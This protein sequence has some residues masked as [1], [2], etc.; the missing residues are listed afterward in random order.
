MW[1]ALLSGALTIG[2]IVLLSTPISIGTTSVPPLGKFLSPSK[3]FW[4]NAEGKRAHQR[5][6]TIKDTGLSAPVTVQLDDRLVP[7]IFA[8]NEV[9]AA[10]A[11]GYILAKF[12]LFQMDLAVRATA[13]TLS[14]IV[15]DRA[16]NYDKQQRN[17]GILWAA[18][19]AV[20]GWS[21]HPELMKVVQ[22]YCDGVNHYINSLPKRKYPL[23]FKLLNYKPELWTPLK[24]ALFIKKM[25]LDL[26][27]DERDLENTNLI[28]LLGKETFDE[29]FPEFNDKDIPIIPKS[30]QW[31][32][33]P[34]VLPD[35]GKPSR[36]IG[37]L[38]TNSGRTNEK[39]Q[40]G[41]NNW[42]IAKENTANG[43]PI[44]CSDPHLSLNLPSIWFENHLITPEF[45]VYGVSLP[46][47]PW[48]V[49][50]FNE[51][52]GW[53]LTN[54]GHDVL[55]W[56]TVD[57]ANQE[58][59]KYWIDGETIAATQRI[60][61]IKIKN[62]STVL[63]TVTYTVWGP[64]MK[65]GDHEGLAMK[66]IAHEVPQEAEVNV[67]SQ[68]NKAKSFD[69]Y[70][71]ALGS[72]SSP[73]QNFAFASI[74]NDI[75]LTIGGKLP[76]R[77]KEQGKFILD[78]SRTSDAWQAYI[79]YEHNPFV[80]NPEQ[81]YVAS[82]NQQTADT[83]YPY[84]YLATPYFEDYRGRMVNQYLGSDTAFTTEDMKSF[85]TSTL[86]LRAKDILPEFL[87]QVEKD[88][89]VGDEIRVVQILE[90][91]DYQYDGNSTAPILFEKLYNKFYDL[92]WDEFES[93]SETHLVAFPEDWRTIEL[94]LK[95][96]DYPFFDHKGTTQLETAHDII[97][98]SWKWLLDSIGKEND[99]L[100]MTWGTY[101]PTEISHLL[102]LDGFGHSVTPGS[103]GDA[104]NAISRT[105]GPSWRMI[106]EF[107]DRPTAQVIYPGGQSGN[108]G[109]PYYD[110]MI[111]DWVN[112]TYHAVKLVTE[113]EDISNILGT[114][115]FN[116]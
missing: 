90:E 76:L 106:V 112:G 113:Q 82:A 105:T 42:A 41:S 92:T 67:F 109:S 2:L 72:F 83:T 101:R 31:P 103:H 58:K 111:D 100:D 63:D 14:E 26:C 54:V 78:G 52:I 61:E 13:G 40:L 55:D 6:I 5:E 85:Q 39:E 45:N 99:L 23:E 88:N 47:V 43:N 25:A 28:Q 59:T 44:L 21:R 68:L 32:F 56:Y 107:T 50:G 65:N 16:V 108:P 36:L 110:N 15:G 102:S 48:V 4:R 84:Y 22:G 114:I 75:A 7:H 9:D 33:D 37:K 98:Q 29:L 49:I 8:G 17:Q 86:N 95:E 77:K 97:D 70:R 93:F 19:N 57:W 116:K 74:N 81:G 20:E 94:A 34:I 104:L 69:D 1:K 91:W 46:G 30:K 53:A 96:P 51:Y 71:K 79:P 80:K 60:E 3:G 24:V 115:N 12:R 38:P 87:N 11:Q 64:V 27:A 10:F 62:R 66:W 73:A 35:Q 18:E 89:L